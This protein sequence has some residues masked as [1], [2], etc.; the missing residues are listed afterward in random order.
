LEGVLFGL[1]GKCFLDMLGVFAEFETNIG[2]E[3]RTVEDGCIA[4]A[5]AT[6]VYKGRPVVALPAPKFYKK[7]CGAVGRPR[8]S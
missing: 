2:R 4:K 5:K 7:T 8:P 6:G 3:R 1:L